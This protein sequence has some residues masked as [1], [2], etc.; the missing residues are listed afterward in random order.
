MFRVNRLPY[1]RKMYLI[2]SIDAEVR[3]ALPD[4]GAFNVQ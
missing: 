1:E 4:M 2:E 3:D